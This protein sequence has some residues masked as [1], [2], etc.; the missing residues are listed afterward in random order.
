MTTRSI[1]TILWILLTLCGAAVLAQNPE[2]A[3]RSFRIKPGGTVEVRNPRGRID[4]RA[5]EDA[6]ESEVSLRIDAAGPLGAGAVRVDARDGKLR[7][8]TVTADGPES[9]VDLSLVVPARTKVRLTTGAG[10]ISL[11]GSFAEAEAESDTGTIYADVPLADLKYKF[12]WTASRPRFLSDVELAETEEKAAGKF[13]IEGAIR[14]EED[15]SGSADPE[16][17]VEDPPAGDADGGETERKQP[18]R[19]SLSFRTARGII[20]L[21]VPPREVPSDLSERPLTEAAK[22]VIRSGDVL[23]TEAIRRASPKYFGEYAATL[24]PRRSTPYLNTSTERAKGVAADVKKVTVQVVDINNRSVNDL[25]LNDFELTERGEQREILSVEPTTAPFNLVLLL[26]VS[27]SVDNYVDFIRKAAR[28]FVN[29]VGRQ[30]RLSIVIFNE[31]VKE[32]SDFTTDRELLSDSLDTFDAGG[33]TAYYDALAYVLTETLRPMKGDR[34]AIVVLSDG[35]DNRSFLPFGALLGSIQES[36]AL[37]Y[38]L[39]VPSGL[40]AAG[41]DSDPAAAVDP[42]RSRFLSQSLTS[43]AR[44]EGEELARISGGVYYP[45][46]RLGQI[47][48]AYDDIVR[49]LRTAYTIKYRSGLAETGGDRASPRLKVRVRKSD[50][51]VRLG[52]VVAVGGA[53]D[54]SD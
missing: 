46:E 42:L 50:T 54:P 30:D 15:A 34:T 47:Q 8:E 10:Q 3:E 39:Y 7:I 13:V 36:G 29:T 18:E 6:D 2:D 27:G 26:D 28:S 25:E 21:N 17:A 11:G 40:I 33:G 5:A 32:L 24:P 41:A 53:K 45:I 4:V 12:L 38:P 44:E 37:I 23:L 43:K 52:P 9:R 48:T 31:D 19:V 1:A 22:A 20:L 35:D 16:T 49:Q 51:F 14:D